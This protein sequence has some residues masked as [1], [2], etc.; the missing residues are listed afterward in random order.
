MMMKMIC[1]SKGLLYKLSIVEVEKVS[2]AVDSSDKFWSMVT[3]R[4]S[5]MI[6]FTCF[7][8]ALSFICVCQNVLR[9]PKSGI[10]NGGFC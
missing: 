10:L 5:G 2:F 8:Q 9:I 6:M 3:T 1:A 7:L 4:F